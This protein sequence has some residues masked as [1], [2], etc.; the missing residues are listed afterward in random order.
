[1]NELLF[2]A[3]VLA[4]YFIWS[5]SNAE[6]SRFPR[7]GMWVSGFCGAVALLFLLRVLVS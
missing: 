5:E 2:L 6:H 7:F 3:N 4:S 1:M